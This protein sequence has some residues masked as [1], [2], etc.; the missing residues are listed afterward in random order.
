[1][2]RGEKRFYWTLSANEIIGSMDIG[3]LNQTT[4]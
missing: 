2:T 4:Y 3:R 1:V